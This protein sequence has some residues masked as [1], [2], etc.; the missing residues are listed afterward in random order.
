MSPSAK[1]WWLGVAAMAMFGLTLP[2][3]QIAIGPADAPRLSPWFVTF[4]RGAVAAGLSAVMLLATRSPWPRREHWGPLAVAAAGNAIAYPLLLA[5][6]LRSVPTTHAAVVTALAPLLTAVV[7]ALV[8]RQRAGRLFWACAVLGCALVVGYS[9]WRAQSAGHGFRLRGEDAWLAAAVLGASVGYVYGARVTPAL[10]AERTIC[11]VTL[12]AL[13]VTLPGAWLHW[14]AQAPAPEAWVGFAYV[15]LFSMWAAFFAWYRALALGGAVRVS[16]V[17]LL[18]PFFAM[19]FA[20][21]LRGEAPEA[22][23]LLFAAAVMATVWVGRRSGP[24]TR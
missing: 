23:S 6:A 11:W 21:P 4:G 14:P 17:Q 7:A 20:W 5:W 22:T 19:A 15:S 9:L 24:M 3:T 8:M 1:G 13:P 10:G 2:M 16:Q 18:Q 12:V